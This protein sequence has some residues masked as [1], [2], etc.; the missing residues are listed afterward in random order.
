M[1]GAI[2]RFMA[3][4]RSPEHWQRQLAGAIEARSTRTETM[5][6]QTIPGADDKALHEALSEVQSAGYAVTHLITGNT[7]WLDGARPY[8]LVVAEKL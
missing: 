5:W 3:G 6:V 7:N 8:V 1:T 4:Q 2:D